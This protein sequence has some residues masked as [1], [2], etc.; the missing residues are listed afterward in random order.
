[1]TKKQVKLS[2]TLYAYLQVAAKSVVDIQCPNSE[3]HL[4]GG[5]GSD[6]LQRRRQLKFEGFSNGGDAVP[7]SSR[8]RASL[9]ASVRRV[10]YVRPANPAPRRSVRGSSPCMQVLDMQVLNSNKIE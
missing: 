1:M 10:R 9:N 6:R 3:W 2:R 7:T 5:V 8:T 4:L